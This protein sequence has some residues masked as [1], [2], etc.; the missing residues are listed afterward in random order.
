MR[1]LV[2]YLKDF[3]KEDFEWL[4]YGAI[5]VFIGLSIS[6]NYSLNFESN[7][8]NTNLVPKRYFAYFLFYSF[9]YFGALTLARITTKN[10]S[11][12]SGKFFLLSIIGMVIMA[13][14]GSFRG[15]YDIAGMIMQGPDR[16]FLGRVISEWQSYFLVVIPLFLLWKTTGS[17][18]FYGL[19]LKNVNL[20]PYLWLLALVVPIVIIAGTLDS[21][22]EQYPMYSHQQYMGFAAL[23]NWLNLAIYEISYGAAFLPVELLFRG[24]LVIGIGRLIGKE[25]IFPMVAAYVF[26]HFEK[27]MGEAI[28]SAFGGYILGIFALRT[29]NIWGGVI[30]H[31]GLAW[32][33][34]LSGWLMKLINE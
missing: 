11:A 18:N 21:F 15:S 33:M 28:S 26:L 29:N 8:V 32:L 4:R 17:G 7:Y 12:L 14:D 1:T 31:T 25:A 30:I 9:A 3:L 23:P 16:W 2:I 22:Q 34:E 5:A 10:R 19:T 20:K 27:P 24:F 6:V 13:V